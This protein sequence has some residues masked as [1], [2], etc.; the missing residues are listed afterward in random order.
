[1]KELD[2]DRSVFS[3]ELTDLGYY[4]YKGLLTSQRERD[5]WMSS[6]S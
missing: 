3:T 4:G 5:E 2:Y 1:M 6:A